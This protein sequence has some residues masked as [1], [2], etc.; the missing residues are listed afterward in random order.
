MILQHLSRDVTLVRVQP[1]VLRICT[2]TLS[3]L[4]IAP[5]DKAPADSRTSGTLPPKA[6]G[7]DASVDDNP[8]GTRKARSSFGRGFFKIK[9]NKR[10]ASAPNLGMC[11]TGNPGPDLPDGG[12]GLVFHPSCVLLWARFSFS[13]VKVDALEGGCWQKCFRGFNLQCDDKS[14]LTPLCPVT[15]SRMNRPN[16]VVV[17]DSVWTVSP[18][19]MG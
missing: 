11:G 8:F 2:L 9:S 6:P 5:Q 14:A 18:L 19:V 16:P 12:K 3:S 15:N 13:E 4:L 10:T 1:P 17:C 7:H